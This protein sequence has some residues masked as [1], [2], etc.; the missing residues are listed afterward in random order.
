MDICVVVTGFND[1]GTI[2]ESIESVLS[3]NRYPEQLGFAHGPSRDSTDE[4]AGFYREEFDFVHWDS[5]INPSQH[6]LAHLRLGSLT[7]IQTSHVMFLRADSYLYRDALRRAFNAS[8][9]ADLIFA[10]VRFMPP[11]GENWD[12]P[13]SDSLKPGELL[14][15]GPL[16]PST[17]IWR[18]S[19]LKDCFSRL[20]TLELGPFSTLGWL[21]VLSSLQPGTSRL[22]EP[23]VETWDFREGENCW[24]REVFTFLDKVIEELE[25]HEEVPGRVLQHLSRDRLPPDFSLDGSTDLNA[26]ENDPES[27]SDFQWCSEHFPMVE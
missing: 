5:R 9:G 4:F 17:V 7:E 3:Q 2:I 10:P 18:T 6:G 19:L 13:V 12:W 21:L 14:S 25:D 1:E 23:M 20:Q 27:E 16:P 24:T 11:D 22:E 26:D 8:D 15:S